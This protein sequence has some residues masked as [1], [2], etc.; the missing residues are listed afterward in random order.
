M[1]LIFLPHLTKASALGL[2]VIKRKQKSP[3]FSL[4]FPVS[5]FPSYDKS[6]RKMGWNNKA[7]LI[8]YFITNIS[9]KNYQNRWMH[10]EVIASRSI[11]FWDSVEVVC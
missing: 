9:A 11:S 10:V 4:S 5:C 2:P 6:T 1:W 3:V 7:S 8:A